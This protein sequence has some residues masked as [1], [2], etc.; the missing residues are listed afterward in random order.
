MFPPALT[1]TAYREAVS[2]VY[3][4]MKSLFTR[5]RDVTLAMGFFA[6]P[7]GLKEAKRE[8]ETKS[9]ICDPASLPPILYLSMRSISQRWAA[10]RTDTAR[11]QKKIIIVWRG[12]K[13]S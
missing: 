7:L 13:R 1:T 12:P 8:R 6:R 10:K 11:E 4:S 5:S 3:T 2:A 9:R